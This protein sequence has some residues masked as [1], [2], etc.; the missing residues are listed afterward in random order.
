MSI[1]LP[2]VDHPL[3]DVVS[4]FKDMVSSIPASAHKPLFTLANGKPLTLGQLRKGFKT[5]VARA[6]L[7]DNLSLH[8]LRSGGASES[9]RLGAEYLDIQRQGVWSSACFFSY[10]SRAAPS[11]STVCSALV[12]AAA[13]HI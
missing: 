13:K 11:D 8:S 2:R 4:A 1:S 5:L 12:A 6:G 3:L 10:L 9:H 7:P